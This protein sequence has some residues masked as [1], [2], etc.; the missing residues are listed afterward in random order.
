MLPVGAGVLAVTCSPSNLQVE[1]YA[2]I[3]AHGSDNNKCGEFCITSHH[4]LF[5]NAFNNTLTFDSAGEKLSTSQN[6]T[7]AV[8]L[9]AR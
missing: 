5:N 3:T 9:R 2:V 4:F 7:I 1:L 6:S 8:L